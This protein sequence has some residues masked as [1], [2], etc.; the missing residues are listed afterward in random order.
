MPQGPLQALTLYSRIAVPAAVVAGTA[1][2]ANAGQDAND[3]LG[4]AGAQVVITDANGKQ[5]TLNAEGAWLVGNAMLDALL[6]GGNFARKRPR[7]SV[8]K[9]KFV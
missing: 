7:A 1:Y 4:S 8:T 3:C 2:A 5:T 6:P 9:V